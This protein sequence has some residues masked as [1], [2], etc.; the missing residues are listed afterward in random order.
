MLVLKPFLVKERI[1]KKN[2]V[3]VLVL[4]LID[5]LGTAARADL[6]CYEGFEYSTGSLAGQGTSVDGWSGAWSGGNYNVQAGSLTMDGMPF[7]SVGGSA[8]GTG[9]ANR[10]FSTAIDTSQEGAY[11][12]SFL[13]QRSGWAAGASEFAYAELLWNA[14]ADWGVSSGEAYN[15]T[16]IG[17]SVLVAGAGTTDPIF[18]VG[19]LLTNTSG[20]PDQI[21]LK[22]YTSGDS[23]EFSETSDWTV[24]GG[25]EDGDGINTVLRLATGTTVGYTAAYDEIRIGTEWSDV[26]V[27]EPATG[28]LLAVGMISLLK[29]RK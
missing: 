1:V 22:A 14:K 8:V 16:N 23:I 5:V 2:L 18:I 25:T 7:A 10:T 12:I 3:L 26:V 6:I 29:R 19:K 11:Y 21:F 13:L 28:V 15:T 27:P 4:V 20:T 9:N 17:S 24:I